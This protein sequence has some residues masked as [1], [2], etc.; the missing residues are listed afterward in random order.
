MVTT[1]VLSNRILNRVKNHG[2][3]V[4]AVCGLPLT[5]GEKVVSKEGRPRR[6]HY[7]EACFKSLWR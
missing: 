3:I 5:P 2:V 7:H 4:C 6:K 1:Y